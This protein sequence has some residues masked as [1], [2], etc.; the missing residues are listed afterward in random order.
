MNN[1]IPILAFL[2][3]ASATYVMTRAMAS[4]IIF[5]ERYRAKVDPPYPLLPEE[6]GEA[7]HAEGVSPI[8]AI[9]LLIAT[10]TRKTKLM[11]TTHTDPE[12]NKLAMKV[13]S[14]FVL[15]MTIVLGGMVLIT[16]IFL[17]LYP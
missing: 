14:S 6:I 8:Q 11:F 2:I 5:L 16:V 13:R 1:L 3:L 15:A 12:L 10:T 7:T 17:K 4:Q 9:W